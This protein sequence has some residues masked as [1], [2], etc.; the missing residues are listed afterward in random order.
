M[1]A[2]AAGPACAGAWPEPKGET[3]AI[4]KYE[5]ASADQAIDVNGEWVSIPRQTDDNLS[6][7]VEH[8]ITS[9]LTFQGKLGYTRGHDDF[10]SYDGRGPIEAGLRYAVVD[11]GRTEVAVYA[12]ATWDGVGR[13]A[14]YAAPGQGSADYEL[15]LLGGRSGTAWRRHVFVDAEIARVWRTGLPNETHVDLT[16]GMDVTRNWLL[17][18]QT[19]AGMADGGADAPIWAKD[20]FSVVRKL[21]PWRLQGG[22]M[23]LVAGREVPV[24]HGPVLGV[25]RTF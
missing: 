11:T 14:G 4:L 1:I 7:Y 18:S 25:W 19:Y 21:G 12:G 24:D 16:V 22:W 15:R 8:G 5:P 9:R 20:E 23:Q 2:A 6:L 10:V 13:N 3:L 17:L